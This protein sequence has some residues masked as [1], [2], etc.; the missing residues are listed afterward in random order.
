MGTTALIT[1]A[2]SGIGL[3][4]AKIHA[5]RGG[6]LV[7]VARREEKLANLKADLE[8]KYGVSVQYIVKD[9]F[10]PN[11][12]KEV[13][14][15]VE[16]RNITVDYLINNAG[17]GYF[18]MFREADWDKDFQTIDLNITVLTQFCKLFLQDMLKQG[19][20]KIMNIA[21][22]AAFQPGPKMAVYYAT[23]AYVL[24]FSEALNNEVRKMGITVT[25]LCPGPTT[26]GFPT[27]VDRTN[28]RLLKILS[29]PTAREV[30]KYGYKAMINGRSVA[31]Y[32]TLNT[33]MATSVRFIPRSLV[34]KTV[35]L[36]QE[37]SKP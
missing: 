11:A 4:L 29:L 28:S 22:S 33:V 5:S 15:E 27:A 23:K 21:S 30:A 32:G 3:E 18:G 25:T 20:G 7:L 8:K 16:N 26:T 19:S 17:F 14:E 36:I 13:Y 37:K 35:R 12:P 31:I 9:L 2:S 34:V 10:I 6:N 1:G 24:H